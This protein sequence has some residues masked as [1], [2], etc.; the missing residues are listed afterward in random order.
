MKTVA[1]YNQNI[2]KIKRA[3][4]VTYNKANYNMTL[5]SEP[6]SITK[7]K[8]GIYAVKLP[9]NCYRNPCELTPI[10]FEEMVLLIFE[11]SAIFI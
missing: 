6:I 5:I 9:N 1:E 8:I 3:K 7:N 2:K 4:F 11:G 10:T